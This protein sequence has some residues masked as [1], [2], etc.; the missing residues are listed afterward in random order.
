MGCPWQECFDDGTGCPYYW[1]INSNAV[2]WEMPPEY[3]IFHN[4]GS[5][6]SAPIIPPVSNLKLPILPPSTNRVSKFDIPPANMSGSSSSIKSV[7]SHK[8]SSHLTKDKSKLEMRRYPRKTSDS[9]DE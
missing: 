9:E 5:V 3:K 2:T 1:N 4:I 6:N 8:L 7:V